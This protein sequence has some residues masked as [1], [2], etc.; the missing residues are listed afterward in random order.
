MNDSKEEP[1][2]LGAGEVSERTR[3]LLACLDGLHIDDGLSIL[4]TSL[5]LLATA[6]GKTTEET[7]ENVR[8]AMRLHQEARNHAL[9]AN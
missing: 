2:R 4:L 8:K 3:E 9:E 5:C 1:A 7:I 6:F